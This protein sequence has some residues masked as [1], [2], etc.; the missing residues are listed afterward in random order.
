MMP[1]WKETVAA[2]FKELFWLVP[3][4]RETGA[5]LRY[6]PTFEYGTS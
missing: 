2:Y 1:I 6:S 5:K 4:R 3:R